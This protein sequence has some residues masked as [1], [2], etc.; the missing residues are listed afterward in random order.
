MLNQLK[1]IRAVNQLGTVNSI[2]SK[3]NPK[4]ALNETSGAYMSKSVDSPTQRP[5]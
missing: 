2:L 4:I 3:F 5:Y 1:K